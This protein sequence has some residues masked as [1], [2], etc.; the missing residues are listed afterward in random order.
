MIAACEAVLRRP[1]QGWYA[2]DM[3]EEL[4]PEEQ[5]VI[6]RVLDAEAHPE[7]C[8]CIHCAATFPEESAGWSPSPAARQTDGRL[9]AAM[10]LF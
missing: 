9:F 7:H 1:E 8:R 4:S 6:D 2:V 10:V 3:P 5:A